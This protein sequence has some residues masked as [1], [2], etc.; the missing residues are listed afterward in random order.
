M[1]IKENKSQPEKQYQFQI[2]DKLLVIETQHK[3]KLHDKFNG[4]YEEIEII[5]NSAK[6]KIVDTYQNVHIYSE[7]PKLYCEN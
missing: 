2:D 3:D 6:I 1:K 7:G 4:P 5:R